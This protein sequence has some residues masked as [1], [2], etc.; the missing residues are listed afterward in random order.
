MINIYSATLWS[1]LIQE[2]IDIF[3]KYPFKTALLVAENHYVCKLST[4]MQVAFQL[5]NRGPNV[6][7]KS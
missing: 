6:D 1:E 7:R 3:H 2:D 5:R 4:A